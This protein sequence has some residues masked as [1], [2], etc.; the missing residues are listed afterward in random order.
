VKQEP[1]SRESETVYVVDDDA[2]M[3]DALDTLFR[4]VGMTTRTFASV[5]EFMDAGV[6]DMPACIVLE[7]DYPA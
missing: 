7:F 5:R 2:S 4:S 1:V 6:S 3:R